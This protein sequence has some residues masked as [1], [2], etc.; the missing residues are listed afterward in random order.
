[1]VKVFTVSVAA[2][3][4]A[5]PSGAKSDNLAGYGCKVFVR[6]VHDL[7]PIAINGYFIMLSLS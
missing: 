5:F 3:E 6:Y 2:G 1:M 7:S 4:L